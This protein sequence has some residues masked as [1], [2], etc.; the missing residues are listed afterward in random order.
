MKV[1]LENIFTNLLIAQVMN[2]V[3]FVRIMEKLNV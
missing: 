3:I 1:K 2:F